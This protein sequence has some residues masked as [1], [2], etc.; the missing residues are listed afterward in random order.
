VADLPEGERERLRRINLPRSTYHAARR[1]CYAESWVLDR[2]VPDPVAFGFPWVA[3]LV[4][5]P[6]ADRARDLAQFLSSHPA[7]VMAAG[8]PQFVLGVAWSE[9]ESAARAFVEQPARNGLA[10][11]S[12]GVVSDAR[13]PFVPV[14]FDYEGAWAHVT[15]TPGTTEYP[16]GLGGTPPSESGPDPRA[17]RTSWAAL[18]LVHRPFAAEAEGR[19][20]HLLGTFGLPWSQRRLLESGTV[21]HRVFLDP[22]KIPPYQGRAADQLVAITGSLREG[23]SPSLLLGTLTQASH[24]FP[25]LLAAGSGRVLILALGRGGGSAPPATPNDFER[26]PPMSKLRDALEGI[27]IV[28]ESMASVSSYLNHRYDRLFPPRGSA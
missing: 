25:I 28:Q 21:R 5:R 27:E 17:R 26:Q 13:R 15:G 8:S 19:P 10:G 18:E 23:Q 3:F 20:G 16:R 11:W 24:V 1:R 7:A 22:G 6:F 2:Y 4:A 9:S 12:Y 14:Y